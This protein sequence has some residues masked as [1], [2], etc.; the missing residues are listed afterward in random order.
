M[1]SSR[2]SRI[3]NNTK[4]SAEAYPTS[5]LKHGPL[6]L[7]SPEVPTVAAVAADDLAERNVAALHEIAARRGPLWVVTQPGVELGD[8]EARRFEVPLNTMRT[9]LRRALIS[10]REC[11]GG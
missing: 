3:T 2:P 11:L 5:E 7:I 10:L 4:L 1:I 8:L 6:A 9:W